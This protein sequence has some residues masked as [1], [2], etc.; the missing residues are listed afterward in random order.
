MM[1]RS[2]RNISHLQVRDSGLTRIDPLG[3][4]DEEAWDEIYIKFR[5]IYPTYTNRQRF[6]EGRSIGKSRR[7][8]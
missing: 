6:D 1:Y 4:E 5:N 7:L 2:F 3:R 8:G